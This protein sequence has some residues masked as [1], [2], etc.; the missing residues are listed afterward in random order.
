MLKR[1]HKELTRRLGNDGVALANVDQRANTIA[2]D[3]KLGERTARYFTGISPS[4]RRAMDNAYHDILR[5]LRT[6]HPALQGLRAPEKL[7]G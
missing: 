4:D 3:F 1:W 2:L 7:H 5:M 6:P